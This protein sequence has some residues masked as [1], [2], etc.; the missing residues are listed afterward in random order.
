MTAPRVDDEPIELT[1]ESVT[2]V[3]EEMA[4]G[5]RTNAVFTMRVTR[6]MVERVRP[7]P[8]AFVAWAEKLERANQ[9]LPQGP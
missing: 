2:R 7:G 5:N 3:L 1:P 6:E 9:P 8:G 4:A